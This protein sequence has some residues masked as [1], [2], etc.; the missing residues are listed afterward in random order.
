MDDKNISYILPG[1]NFHIKHISKLNKIMKK[2][3]TNNN[4]IRINKQNKNKNGNVFLNDN[5]NYNTI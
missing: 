3:K 2:N 5:H 1:K 4:S